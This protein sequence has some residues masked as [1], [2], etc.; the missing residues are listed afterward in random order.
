MRAPRSERPEGGGGHG[1]AGGWLLGLV[2]I[3]GPRAVRGA[4]VAAPLIEGGVASG[5]ARRSSL[6]GCRGSHIPAA[7]NR[8]VTTDAG[9]EISALPLFHRPLSIS[10]SPFR[11][12]PTRSCSKP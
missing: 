12:S 8:S 2:L 4:E 11:F 1:A 9:H 6:A 10:P 3:M 7:P 5:A